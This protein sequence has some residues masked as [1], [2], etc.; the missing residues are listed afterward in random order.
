MKAAGSSGEVARTEER[1][2]MKWVHGSQEAREE[3]LGQ[4][5]EGLHVPRDRSGG[6]S[7]G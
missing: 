4:A 3:G 2:E 1:K 7:R 6:T 5:R